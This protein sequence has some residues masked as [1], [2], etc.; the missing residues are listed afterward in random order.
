MGDGCG[1]VVVM[2][3]SSSSGGMREELVLLGDDGMVARRSHRL[4]ALKPCSCGGAL[5][6]KAKWCTWTGRSNGDDD[7]HMLNC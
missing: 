5:A 1:G 3:G 2:H 6:G 7:G 4:V